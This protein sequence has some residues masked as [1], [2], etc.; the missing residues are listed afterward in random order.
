MYLPGCPPRP[1]M[2]IDAILKLHHKIMNEPLG[3][4]AR[5][6]SCAGPE[7]RARPVVS[8]R[9]PAADAAGT[10]DDS[11]PAPGRRSTRPP[12]P[13]RRPAPT[14][15]DRARAPRR[16]R[17]SAA[18]EPAR[19]M[20]GVT[21]SGDTSGFGGL[22]AGAV[23][24]A[25]RAAL[26]RLLRRG[27]RR[28]CWRD[29]YA[30]CRPTPSADRRRPRRA[31][32]LHQPRAPAGVA[33]ALRDDPALRF[34]LCARCPAWTTS[35]TCRSGCTSVYHLTSMTYRRRIRLE[36]C[37]RPSR[38]RTCPSWSRSTRRPTG[39]SARPGTCSASSSTATR[40]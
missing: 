6:A 17:R 15:G 38:T 40:R 18:T 4:E 31:H 9:V 29:A 21:G 35:A 14:V 28:R 5:R 33:A 27:R 32:L 30:G 22:R 1:E 20:F 25:R 13:A 2:L 34:E 8:Q 36:V 23:V 16:D 19:G 26:R 12:S 24:A 3:A 7:G 10:S 39:R 11:R 37:G